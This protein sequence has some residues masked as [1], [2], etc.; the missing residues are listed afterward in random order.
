MRNFYHS[1]FLGYCLHLYSVIFTKF[2][3]IC[4]PAFF[5]SFLSK[6]CEYNQDEDNSL[7]TLSDKNHQASSQ[8]FL[9]VNLS[10]YTTW[11]VGF[12]ACQPL[13]GYLMPLFV[14]NFIIWFLCTHLQSF[15]SFKSLNGISTLYGLF[16]AILFISKWLLA[17]FSCISIFTF[18]Y[19]STFDL[20]RT[21]CLV[22]R[23]FA[24]GPGDLGSIPGQVI[25]KTKKKCYLVSS[26]IFFWVFGMTNNWQIS[27]HKFKSLNDK[28]PL[29]FSCLTIKSPE[30]K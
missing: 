27:G 3:P 25:P 24:N 13:L 17:M 19:T 12:M 21:I 28:F 2:W 22:G 6:C 9:Q 30:N 7:K 15:K 29:I 5:R 1:R 20:N 26:N 18:L 23:V 8:K 4:P 10:V 14:S 16:E 11:L